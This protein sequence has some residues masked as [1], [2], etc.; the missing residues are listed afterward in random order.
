MI[1]FI[2]DVDVVVLCWVLIV[3]DEVFIC[4]D[5]VEMLW[6]EGYEIVGEVGDG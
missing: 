3:E 4:M 2:I 1:G 5:L 6:E